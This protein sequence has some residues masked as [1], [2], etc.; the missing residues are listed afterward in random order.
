MF[1]VFCFFFPVL[2]AFACNILERLLLYHV[3]VLSRSG[4][5]LTMQ[6]GERK[7]YGG[8]VITF[9]STVNEITSVIFSH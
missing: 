5:Q 1:F 8:S 4:S 7:D 6:F 9:S 2:S 3:N